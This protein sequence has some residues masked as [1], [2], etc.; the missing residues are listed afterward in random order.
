MNNKRDASENITRSNPPLFSVLIANYNNARYLHECFASI[1]T[2]SYQNWEIVVVDDAS[3]DHSH[4]IYEQYKNENRIRIILNSRNMGCGFSKRRCVEKAYGEIC[5]FVDADDAL[6]TDA[7]ET[8]VRYHLDYPQHSIIYSTHYN[9]NEQMKSE[10][11]AEN[12]G[13]IPHDTKS[14]SF[15]NLMISHFATFKRELYHQTSGISSWLPKAVDKDLY[16]KLEQT[17]PVLF[18]NSP[19]Y[20]YRHHQQSI[21]LNRN[22]AIAYHYHLAVKSFIVLNSVNRD[23]ILNKMPHSKK[24]LAQGLI[25]SGSDLILHKKPAIGIRLIGK[26]LVNFPSG[27]FKALLF[28]MGKVFRIR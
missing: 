8:M 6:T 18:V 5:G 21:S 22:A 20:F 3:T 11:I 17:G 12:V 7:I 19:L 23:L 14:W 4:E 24:D 2:Q 25:V 13:Q 16:Y 26:S 10:N 28:V 15:T 27:S 1:F 9:C